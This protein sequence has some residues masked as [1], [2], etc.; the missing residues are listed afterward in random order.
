MIKKRLHTSLLRRLIIVLVG[1][2]FLI[3]SEPAS[4]AQ[5]GSSCQGAIDQETERY[6]DRLEELKTL[7]YEATRRYRQDVIK[8][9]SERECIRAAQTIRQQKQKDIR[10]KR[11]EEAIEHRRAMD[12]IR[13]SC[14]RTASRTD[15]RDDEREVDTRDDR[16]N[17]TRRRDDRGSTDRSGGALDSVDRIFGTAERLGGMVGRR[18]GRRNDT[19]DNTRSRSR[20]AADARGNN[21]VQEETYADLDVPAEEAPVPAATKLPP[22][23]LNAEKLDLGKGSECQWCEWHCKYRNLVVKRYIELTR[24]LMRS[25]AKLTFLI[26]YKI[27]N[28]SGVLNI[29]E[30][31]IQVQAS[32]SS[33]TYGET[34]IKQFRQMVIPMLNELVG[35]EPEQLRFPTDGKE[36]VERNDQFSLNTGGPAGVRFR[37]L[38]PRCDGRAKGSVKSFV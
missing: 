38:D 14:R 30:E 29:P 22:F 10:I 19:E 20:G 31:E 5:S 3:G 34:Q 6:M 17:R 11:E 15:E 16:S 1:V 36:Y 2:M 24:P 8:C 9:S 27:W 4:N 21:P 25:G 37:A 12:Q 35:S 33:G 32:S 28:E 23:S 18:A 26:T 13:K 7:E